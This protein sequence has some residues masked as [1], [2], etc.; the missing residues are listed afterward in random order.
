MKFHSLQAV[1]RAGMCCAV[2]GVVGSLA[3]PLQA[4]D[5]LG[6]IDLRVGF[7][8]IPTKEFRGGPVDGGGE[9]FRGEF[10][11]AYRLSIKAIGPLC[12]VLPIGCSTY[13]TRPSSSAAI[14]TYGT[15]DELMVER[16]WQ[17]S[18]SG[19]TFDP[20]V[21]MALNYDFYKHN[22]NRDPQR[23][24][25]EVTIDTVSLS[26]FF[27]Y[28]I[29]MRPSRVGVLHAELTAFGSAG[30]SAL[31]WTEYRQTGN[32]IV[33]QSDSTS[34]VYVEGGLNLGFYY[35]FSAGFQAGLNGSLMIGRH[36]N[37]VF[38]ESAKFEVSGGSVGASLGWRF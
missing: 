9:Q 3:S 19:P 13:G 31:S 23:L 6:F 30:Y 34:S 16:D 18:Y 26:L 37:E 12:S 10:N 11:T 25:P 28:G 32:F 33:S 17:V 2:I 20:L 29:S 1:T 5:S 35:T 24:Q 22:G 4:E 15:Y 14:D 38:R 21:G 27:G 7:S 36:F 8:T